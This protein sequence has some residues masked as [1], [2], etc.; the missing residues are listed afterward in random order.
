MGIVLNQSFKNTIITYI[1][2]GIGA[3]NTLY[4]YPVFLGAT[5]YGL[6]NYV[7]SCANVIMPLFAIGM[8]NTLVKFYSQYQTEEEKSRFLSFTV[9]FPLLLIIPLLLIGL[10][11]YD[12]ILFFLSKKNAIV[13]SYIWLIPF[14]GLSMAYFEIF[15]AWLRVN[16]HSV[17]GNFVK[18]VGLRL[19]SLFL[20]IGVYYNWLSVEGF[21]Y[22]TAILYFLAFL[23][24]MLY[25][26][27]IQKP[28]FQFTIPTNTKDIL[29]YTFYIILSGSVANLLL[30]GDKMIL[31]QYMQIE[32]I[33]F[34][35]VATYIALVISVPSRAMHQIVYP[36]TA[37][38]MHE[39]K[40]DELNL[41]YKKTSINLQMV[42]GF[43]MLCIFV[44]INQL[45]ELVPKE[46]SGGIAVVFM[47]GL[48]KYFDLILGNNNA[49]I[50]NTK[51]YRMVLYLGLMLVVLTVV[52]N[53]IFIP[54]FGIFGSAFATLLS[55]T[56]YSLAKLLFV[57]KKLHLYPFTKETLSSML[58]TFVLFLVFYFWE[59]P[60]YQLISIAL[61]SI[62]VTI[63]Y[64]Y[65]NYKFNISPD[66]NKVIDNILKRIG[67]KI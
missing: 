22:A 20:L 60:F 55:I 12:E 23:I 39:N 9:L 5:F 30:D 58:L 26:F 40:H 28:T 43:V 38:L 67:I 44:N 64:V 16:M 24:T 7:T 33:A 65:L 51:Y 46:Y 13:K 11:F 32:N 17:F 50:F 4:L 27:S 63:L 42:G 2:F 37:K 25:A 48:S 35:S 41:L 56:L 8:Q 21:V 1:G 3:I 49:I 66:I 62:L 10:V 52:L 18:E 31:N 14:I 54:I 36:I 47:I 15:Y 61:K 59:F 34:Y 57:V 45:Y 6:T 19:F 29:V 53:M